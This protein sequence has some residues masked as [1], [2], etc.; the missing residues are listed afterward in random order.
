MGNAIKKKSSKIINFWFFILT[1]FL[2]R[3]TGKYNIIDE[4]IEENF[5]KFYNKDCVYIIFIVYI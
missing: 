2:T 1:L 3:K 5:D 4:Y